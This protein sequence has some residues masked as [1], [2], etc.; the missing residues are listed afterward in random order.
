MYSDFSGVSGSWNW[1]ILIYLGWN[2]SAS[3]KWQWTTGRI[4][5][6]FRFEIS[7]TLVLFIYFI[8]KPN[9]SF[10]YLFISRTL[11]LFI[12]L[13]IS[14]TLVLF[15]YFISLIYFQIEQLEQ[16]ELKRENMV[17]YL[18]RLNG[19]AFFKKKFIT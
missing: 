11:V 5:K 19:R 12:Y 15:I 2:L 4:S 6:S 10:T 16:K 14:R 1:N 13:F 3:C 8:Y 18:L 7:R 9:I 17:I